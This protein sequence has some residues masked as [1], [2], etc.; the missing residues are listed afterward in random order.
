MFGNMDMSNLGDMVNQF[1]KQAEELKQENENKVFTAKSGGGM[2]SVSMN[3]NGDVVDLN[4][5]D[6]MMEDKDSLQILL[7]SAINDAI[8]MSEDNKKNATMDML[9]GMN[10]FGNQK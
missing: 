1:Q 5:D 3:G 6:E 7:I 8:K 10:I 2:V 4:I 9:G